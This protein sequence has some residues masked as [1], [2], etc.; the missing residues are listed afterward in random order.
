MKYCPKCKAEYEDWVTECTDCQVELVNELPTEVNDD[1]EYKPTNDKLVTIYM[2]LNLPPIEVAKAILED[3]GIR[4][5]I[6]GADTLRPYLTYG[7]GIELQVFES[8]QE[9]A[10]KIIKEVNI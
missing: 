2:N 10:A 7:M 5:V 9:K 6:K 1:I 8:D 4:S 3:Y